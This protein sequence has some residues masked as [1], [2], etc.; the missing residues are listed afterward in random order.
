[1][2]TLNR[3]EHER[4]CHMSEEIRLQRNRIKLVK[5]VENMAFPCLAAQLQDAHLGGRERAVQ[6]PGDRERD[7]EINGD[8]EIESR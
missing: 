5:R 4:D 3:I 1:M 7:I 6:I 8:R 2:E